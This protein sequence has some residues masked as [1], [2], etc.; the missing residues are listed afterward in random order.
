M[1]GCKY[2]DSDMRMEHNQLPKNSFNKPSLGYRARERP[3]QRWID[4]IID[5][6]NKHGCTATETTH[7]ALE[8]KLKLTSLHLTAS[9]DRTLVSSSS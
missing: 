5:I 8:L 1:R 7:L 6:L 2:N 4:N 3:R 9:E